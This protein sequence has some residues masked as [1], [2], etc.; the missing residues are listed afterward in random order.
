MGKTRDKVTA[1]ADVLFLALFEWARSHKRYIIA[2][3]LIEG[4]VHSLMFSHLTELKA[5]T[6]LIP[7]HRYIFK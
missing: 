5:M 6:E 3:L 2:F 1:A 7:F 4:W